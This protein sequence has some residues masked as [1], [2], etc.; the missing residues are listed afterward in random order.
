MGDYIFD[1]LRKT[2]K[3]KVDVD[4]DKLYV[5]FINLKDGSIHYSAPLKNLIERVF[6]SSKTSSI[7]DDWVTESITNYD[8][9]FSEFVSECSLTLQRDGWEVYHKE[10]GVI[11]INDLSKYLTNDS[12]IL[13]LLFEYW[14]ETLKINQTEKMMM[15]LYR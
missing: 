5:T 8:P 1:Y 10:F 7:F 14:F 2:Y 11:D 6:S 3:V 15:D 13:I 4:D 12:K 9:Y